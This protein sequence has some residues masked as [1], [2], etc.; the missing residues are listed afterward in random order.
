VKRQYTRWIF[1]AIARKKRLFTGIFV[2][3][4]YNKRRGVR[5][6]VIKVYIKS[7]HGRCVFHCRLDEAVTLAAGLNKVA[8]QMLWGQLPTPKGSATALRPRDLPVTPP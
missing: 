8:T 3:Y 2:G 6:D 7:K 4:I 1:R 5:A